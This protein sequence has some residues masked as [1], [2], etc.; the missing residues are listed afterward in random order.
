MTEQEPGR[1]GLPLKVAATWSQ[2]HQHGGLRLPG[3]NKLDFARKFRPASPRRQLQ[4]IAPYKVALRFVLQ[5]QRQG[6]GLVEAEVIPANA[7][8]RWC[9]DTYGRKKVS[10]AHDVTWR[11]DSQLLP[12]LST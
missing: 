2:K 11:G 3:G 1:L 10:S 7:D 12:E 6:D 8:I 9:R 4:R 5:D